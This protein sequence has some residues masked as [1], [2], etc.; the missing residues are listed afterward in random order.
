MWIN[1]S[2]VKCSLAALLWWLVTGCTSALGTGAKTIVEERYRPIT[3]ERQGSFFVGGKTIYTDLDLVRQGMKPVK[4]I[5]AINRYS[6]ERAWTQF[7]IG[8]SFKVPFPR[9]QFPVEA[10]DQYAAQL[11]PAWRDPAETDRNV[12]ALVALF[13]RI[14]PGIL[15]TWSQSGLFGWRTAVQRSNLV[16]AIVSLEPSMISPGGSSAGLKPADLQVLGTIPILL[17]VGDFDSAR[18]KSLA[19]FANS[20]GQNVSVLVL[21]EEGISGNGHV[22]MI[23]KNNL[24]VAD[25]IIQRVEKT[26][27]GLKAEP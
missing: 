5:P 20:I 22:V 17:Q 6:H 18:I 15:M 13:D 26:V 7:R 25:L 14:G 19:S 4:E 27:E 21:P 2:A 11:V 23:E 8:P 10:F 24:Q 9:T 3:I 12:A 1:S 16:K